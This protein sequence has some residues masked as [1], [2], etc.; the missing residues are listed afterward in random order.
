MAQQ[1]YCQ[2]T[3]MEWIVFAQNSYVEA[4]TPTG[5]YLEVG[6]LVSK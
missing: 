3:T 5:L 6:S 2:M 4:F 1:F